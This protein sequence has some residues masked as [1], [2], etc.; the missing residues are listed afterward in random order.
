MQPPLCS[1]LYT[2]YSCPDTLGGGY[3]CDIPPSLHEATRNN[4]AHHFCIFLAQCI[5]ICGYYTQLC[6]CYYDCVYHNQVGYQRVGR[7][8]NM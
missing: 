5:I 6:A 1:P 3:N 7:L 8:S 2:L 4:M